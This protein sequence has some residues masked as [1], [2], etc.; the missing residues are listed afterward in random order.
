MEAGVLHAQRK[1]LAVLRNVTFFSLQELNAAILEQVKAFNLTPFQK[2]PGTRQR[3]FEEV[4]R[5]ALRPLPAN[6]YE[7]GA[8]TGKRKVGLDYHVQIE[9]HFYSVPHRYLGRSVR[10]LIC[11]CTVEIYRRA[12]CVSCTQS[13][14]RPTHDDADPYAGSPPGVCEVVPQALHP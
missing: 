8:W 10:G 3:R 14:Q 11:Q 7:Y 2:M 12:D 5:P 1:I 13:R 4:D 9:K 6:P